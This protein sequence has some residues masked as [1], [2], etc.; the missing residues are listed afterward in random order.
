MAV[1]SNSISTH[2]M[3]DRFMT[4][5]FPE[6]QRICLSMARRFRNRTRALEDADLASDAYIKVWNA[7]ESVISADNPM[8]V[9]MRIVVNSYID[10]CRSPRNGEDDPLDFDCPYN[11][12]EKSWT[13][14]D[15]L[16][17]LFTPLDAR[18]RQIIERLFGIG[19]CQWESPCECIA[20]ELGITRQTVLSVKKKALDKM[21]NRTVKRTSRSIAA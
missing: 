7:I 5:N 15:W 8:A 19:S 12:Q 9:V 10:A 16:E 18:E 17:D 4:D 2:A 1:I 6:I 3:C 14:E 11:G 20:S 13:E 21:I